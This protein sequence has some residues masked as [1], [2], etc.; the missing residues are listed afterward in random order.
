MIKEKFNLTE[1]EN[2]MCF[3]I[4]MRSHT[5]SAPY[6]WEKMQALAFLYTMIPVINKYYPEKEDRPQGCP[7]RSA[8]QQALNFIKSGQKPR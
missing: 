6:C 5:M 8:V 3:Q 4:A 2:K 1:E 7:S